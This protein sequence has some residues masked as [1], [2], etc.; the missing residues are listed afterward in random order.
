MREIDKGYAPEAERPGIG[1]LLERARQSQ[2]V[3]L[4]KA[5]RA[6]RIRKYY[7]ERPG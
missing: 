7:L 4:E 1:H 2:G 3:A 5:E 6:T